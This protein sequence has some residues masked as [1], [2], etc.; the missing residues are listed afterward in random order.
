MRPWESIV[1][2]Q[3]RTVYARGGYGKRAGL[4]NRPCL[5]IV[6]VT[7]AFTGT[8]PLPI[9]DA[10]REFTT[11]CGERA[12][13]ALPNIR[14]L[15]LACRRRKLPIVYTTGDYSLTELAIRT[16]KVQH[17]RGTRAKPDGFPT[18]ITPAR[19]ELV[20]K[21]AMAS[22]FFGT[23]LTTY[24]QRRV[25]DSVIVVG[26]STSGCV[27]ASAVDAYSN[28]YPVFVV[29]DCCFDRSEFSHLT[30]L[31]DIN[32]KYGTVVTLKEALQSISRLMTDKSSKRRAK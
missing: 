25:V 29:E 16:T 18:M 6:D 3:D 19:G 20:M 4:G 28:G 30:N 2:A 12:W 26:V 21:K 22:A 24:L 31:F 14:R 11:S 8:R 13:K 17:V 32:A 27:R 15:L 10:M 7:F 5:L 23:P 1:P 9:A